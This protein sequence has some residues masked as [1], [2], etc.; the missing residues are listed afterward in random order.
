MSQGSDDGHAKAGAKTWGD[1]DASENSVINMFFLIAPRAIRLNLVG[2][3]PTV[4]KARSQLSLT[5]VPRT[6]T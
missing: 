6:H 2:G 1:L 4:A 3:T 5:I